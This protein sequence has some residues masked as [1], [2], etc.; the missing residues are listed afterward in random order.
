M[1]SIVLDEGWD[2]VDI[3]NFILLYNHKNNSQI[4]LP[5]FRRERSVYRNKS[6]WEKD[7]QIEDD[8]KKKNQKENLCEDSGAEKKKGKNGKSKGGKEK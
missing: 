1:I 4:P 7:S 6:N 3:E 5:T 8:K 2:K